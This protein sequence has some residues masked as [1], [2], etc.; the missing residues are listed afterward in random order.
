MGVQLYFWFVYFCF[1]VMFSKHADSIYWAIVSFW[2]RGKYGNHSSIITFQV[3]KTKW[4]KYKRMQFQCKPVPQMG[5]FQVEVFWVKFH[6]DDNPS[7]IQ[8]ILCFQN[9]IAISEVHLPH[10]W[11]EKKITIPSFFRYPDLHC[12][13]QS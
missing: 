1:L 3:G 9:C 8:R 10:C 5:I 7:P 4:R 2:M 12:T 6:Y 13:V 11:F